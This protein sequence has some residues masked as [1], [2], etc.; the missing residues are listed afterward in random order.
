MLIS[1]T[2]TQ[3][4]R[5]SLTYLVF[6]RIGILLNPRLQ[7]HQNA[8]SAVA[9]LQCMALL[10]SLLHRMPVL[11]TSGTALGLGRGGQ[12]FDRGDL[13]AIGLHCKHGARLDRLPIEVDRACATR[14]R[15]TA[16]VG[17]G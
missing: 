6:C 17:A 5:E 11:I 15:V 1:G 4:T 14:R 2:A 8:W 13:G 10:E 3:I 7:R 9:A 12:T 16:D